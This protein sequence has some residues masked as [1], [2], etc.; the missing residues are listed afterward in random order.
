[1]VQC[2]LSLLLVLA[3]RS[4]AAFDLSSYG[5]ATA[6]SAPAPEAPPPLQAGG[7]EARAATC[8]ASY[9]VNGAEIA[10]PHIGC[11][12]RLLAAV[13]SPGELSALSAKL[14][15]AFGSAQGAKPESVT[16]S[17]K[18]ETELAAANPGAGLVSLN[19]FLPPAAAALFNS[20]PNFGGPNCFNAAFTAAGL[21]D[22]GKL[23]H[24]GN[25][26]ADQLFSM[27]F[28]KVSPSALK[29]GD[30]VVL[31]DGDHAVYYLGAGLVFHKKSYLKQHIYRIAP[32]ERAYEPEPFEWKPGPFDGGSPFNSSEPIRKKEA[33]RPNGAQYPFGQATP[34]ETAK[35]NMIIFLTD[36]VELQAP[37]W[38]LAREL[39]YFTERLLENLVSD[40]SG[41]AESPNP[42]IRAYYRR[43][44]SLR[45]Q[46]N[47]SIET[48]LLSS[49]HAQ[50]N[51][52]EILKRA[53]LPRNDYSRKL[54]AG[55][56]SLYGRDQAQTGRVLDAIEKDF[57]G[58]PLEHV[59]P[60]PSAK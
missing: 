5:A 33:W 45:D 51:A 28:S 59:K 15:R 53:W 16:P 47:Q 13:K 6:A 46:A 55:L 26:E 49:P 23:R 35:V 3:P 37:R 60:A 34:E 18:A 14:S 1:M 50:S 29:P 20:E 56:L 44:E 9:T 7:Q 12:R 54:I 40:W 2:L 57:D 24:V 31:N 39:G 48:E 42:V 43:L 11:G 41:M 10:V 30:I 22:P 36:S 21:M 17:S 38:A 27:Y 25:P 4:A 19:S 52:T 8:Y 32:L 58:Q